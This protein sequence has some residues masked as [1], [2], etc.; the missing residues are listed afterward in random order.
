MAFNVYRDGE[1]ERQ[2]PPG[3][4][5]ELVPAPAGLGEEN[6]VNVGP[7]PDSV[8]I[9]NQNKSKRKPPKRKKRFMP[10][11]KGKPQKRPLPAS[12]GGSSVS[13]QNPEPADRPEARR[14]RTASNQNPDDA[15][16]DHDALGS[17][18]QSEL[19]KRLKYRIRKTAE[20]QKTVTSLKS[21]VARLKEDA[22]RGVR[23]SREMA[24]EH[25][26]ELEGKDQ[27]IKALT[28]IHQ[29]ELRGKDDELRKLSISLK[30]EKTHNMVSTRITFFE[31]QRFFIC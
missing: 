10:T 30:S 11:L 18:S 31:I 29:V 21:D 25:A 23:H 24:K 2:V 15:D 1:E 19:R 14:G 20:L 16:Q 12:L 5:S 6:L 22:G 26:G 13:V 28:E 27:R 9:S 3:P 8:T 4:P 17:L 7:G